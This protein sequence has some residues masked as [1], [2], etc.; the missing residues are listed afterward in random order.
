[1]VL[2]FLTNIFKIGTNKTYFLLLKIL[3][4]DLTNSQA[5]LKQKGQKKKKKN[6]KRSYPNLNANMPR[7]VKKK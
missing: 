6:E 3:I 1:M 4:N 7:P 2:N 5:N